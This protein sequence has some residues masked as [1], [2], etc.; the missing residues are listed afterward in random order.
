VLTK[1]VLPV[2]RLIRAGVERSVAE[3]LPASLFTAASRSGTEARHQVGSQ[4]ASWAAGG[5]GGPPLAGDR[6]LPSH[7]KHAIERSEASAASV[8]RLARSASSHPE[9]VGYAGQSRA[10]RL[11]TKK[12]FPGRRAW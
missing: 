6:R 10:W 8:F 4:A 9:G 3:V 1:P 12:P 7:S 11:L 5:G 2:S